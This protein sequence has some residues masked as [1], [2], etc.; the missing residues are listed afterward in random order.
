MTIY[1]VDIYSTSAID[2]QM[3]TM[4]E[5]ILPS[6]ATCSTLFETELSFPICSRAHLPVSP[7]IRSLTVAIAIVDR[8]ARAANVQLLSLLPPAFG[9][10]LL[11]TPMLL[12]C[13]FLLRAR[14]ALQCLAHG[15]QACSWEQQRY[16]GP[17]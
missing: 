11:D 2:F 13:R 14:K 10:D 1:T 4:R 8:L 9:A 6:Q 7:P 15:F 17:G 3:H 12:G 16:S 5:I